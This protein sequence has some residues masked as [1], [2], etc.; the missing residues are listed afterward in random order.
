MIN[1][2]ETEEKVSILLA[3]YNEYQTL[4][5]KLQ[6]ISD[7]M[8]FDT[9]IVWM[10]YKRHAYVNS[11]HPIKTLKDLIVHASEPGDICTKRFHYLNAQVKRLLGVSLTDSVAFSPEVDLETL[12]Q[13]PQIEKISANEN[14]LTTWRSHEYFKVGDRV[15]KWENYSL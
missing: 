13:S 6:E 9:P 3:Q 1:H 4:S 11:G 15:A 10:L 8:F 2:E 12:A 7:S 14:I 5:N